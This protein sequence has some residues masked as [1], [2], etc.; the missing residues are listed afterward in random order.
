MP[1]RSP[2]PFPWPRDGLRPGIT[3]GPDGTIYFGSHDGRLYAVN[4]DGTEQW[5]VELDFRGLSSSPSVGPD[6]TIYVISSDLFAIDPEGSIRWS[7]PARTRGGR[8]APVLGADGNVYIRSLPNGPGR[9]A[10]K[11]LDAQGDS[12]G[13]TAPKDG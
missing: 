6:G 3:I 13:T 8:A 10:V 7:Y 9:S 11:A 5:S 2:G 1:H 4:P 12:S